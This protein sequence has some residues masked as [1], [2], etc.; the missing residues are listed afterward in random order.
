MNTAKM[1]PEIRIII[2]RYKFITY[3]R[4]EKLA[5]GNVYTILLAALGTS[6][7]GTG[8]PF[9]LKAI[10]KQEND[11]TRENVIQLQPLPLA[12]NQ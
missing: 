12:Y 11:D 9:E 3:K 1:G 2:Q 6:N 5:S 8:T 4:S 10:C 7:K